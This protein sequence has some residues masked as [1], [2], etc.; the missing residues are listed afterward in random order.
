MNFR[1]NKIDLELRNKVKE[2][3]KS[4][5][6]HRKGKISINS[7]D[8]GNEQNKRDFSKELKKAAKKKNKEDEAESKKFKELN[9]DKGKF[10]D[11]KK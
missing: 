7:I 3:T 5:V 10:I 9:D 8:K 6:V 1:I 4:G 11:I 2:T